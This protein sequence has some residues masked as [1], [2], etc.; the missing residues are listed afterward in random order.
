[1]KYN[2]FMDLFEDTYEYPKIAEHCGVPEN[3]LFC[4]IS[5]S[6]LDGFINYF[7][8][9]NAYVVHRYRDEPAPKEEIEIFN[10]THHSKISLLEDDVLILSQ[11]ERDWWFFWYDQDCSDCAIERFSKEIASHNTV[12]RLFKEFCVGDRKHFYFKGDGQQIKLKGWVGR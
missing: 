3:T 12:Q 4:Y 2:N 5:D 10:N 6:F 9:V 1:M 8:F 7:D 11:S